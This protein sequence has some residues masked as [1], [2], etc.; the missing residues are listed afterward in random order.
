M[1]Q[2]VYDSDPHLASICLPLLIYH[3]AQIVLG[4]ALVPRLK[5]FVVRKNEE[6]YE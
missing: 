4:G 3:P 2:L 1:A 5:A 6:V